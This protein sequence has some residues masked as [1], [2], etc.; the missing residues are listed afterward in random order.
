MYYLWTWIYI[1]IPIF[2]LLTVDIP[3]WLN[4]FGVIIG[5]TDINGNNYDNPYAKFMFTL[6]D[7]WGMQ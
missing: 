1:N 2:Q 7:D 6:G 5:T 3:F 4:V